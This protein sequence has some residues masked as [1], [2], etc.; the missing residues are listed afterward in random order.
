MDSS[1]S[2]VTM[3][4]I[5]RR[6]GVSRSTVSFVLNDRTTNVR[7][8]EDTRQR[9]LQTA[10]EMGYRRNAMATVVATGHNP[11][12]GFV[13]PFPS[14][15]WAQYLVGMSN[16]AEAEGHFVKVLATR[17]VDDWSALEN[18]A[19]DRCIELRLSG[20]VAHSINEVALQHLHDALLT[21]RIPVA[22]LGNPF[23]LSWGISVHA[24]YRQGCR[25]SIEH[26]HGLGHRRIAMVG[27]DLKH[28]VGQVFQDSFC[29]AAR[30]FGLKLPARYLQ[31]SYWKTHHTENVVRD[32]MKNSK[33]APRLTA[34]CCINDEMAMVVMR[35]V[36]SLGLRVPQDVSV[37]GWVNG[38]AAEFADP[39]L[40]S[41]A[42]PLEA[43]GHCLAQ[44]LM[45]RNAA[46]RAKSESGETAFD[47]SPLR[48]ALPMRLV[49][50]DSSAVPPKEV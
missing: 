49:V 41:V 22:V 8:S 27:G 48:E 17:Y 16:A 2:L 18:D 29:A 43:M 47:D 23:P 10:Q 14:D 6:A 11:V 5:A 46:H 50:R 24:D 9:I 40:T 45:A 19:I 7:I 1:T 34:I 21:Y 33:S 35:T 12:I 13:S 39:S 42:E 32:L 31:Q 36:R 30:D 38:R 3:H 20:V 25:L 15:A 26:L 37:V 4:D 28:G 44:R